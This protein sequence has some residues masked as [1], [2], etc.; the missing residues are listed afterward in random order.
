MLLFI[1]MHDKHQ[2][3]ESGNERALIT[4]ANVAQWPNNKI[5]GWH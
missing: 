1:N 4:T 2:E 3:E 5:V